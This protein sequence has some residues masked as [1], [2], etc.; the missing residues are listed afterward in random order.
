MRKQNEIM[1]I[2]KIIIPIYVQDT[3]VQKGLTSDSHESFTAI[4]LLPFIF[5]DNKTILCSDVHMHYDL[6]H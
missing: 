3:L 1:D 2:I 6:T 4:D 5:S